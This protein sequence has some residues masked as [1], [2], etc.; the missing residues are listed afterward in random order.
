MTD[1]TTLDQIQAL[2]AQK[3]SATPDQA[4]RIRRQLRALGYRISEQAKEPNAEPKITDGSPRKGDGRARRTPKLPP[5][6]ELVT[7]KRLTS[8]PV[9]TED[10]IANLAEFLEQE[11][12][13]TPRSPASLG[14]ADY[15]YG[16]D[17]IGQLTP[18][19][20]IDKFQSR[21]D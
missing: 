18:Q 8:T 5:L 12:K 19:A 3:A 13:L 20:I 7:G 17:L 6:P 21:W 16:F 1:Q 14:E 10:V 11:E 4:R 15:G 2:L 9:M